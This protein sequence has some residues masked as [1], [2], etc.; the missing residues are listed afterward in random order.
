MTS[1]YSDVEIPNPQA[2]E[3]PPEEGEQEV[4]PG[5]AQRIL[6]NQARTEARL[7]TLQRIVG[8]AQ[9][10]GEDVSPAVLKQVERLAKDAEE[11]R[12]ERQIERL[13]LTE[14]QAAAF[15][16]EA[17]KEESKPEAKPELTEAILE[18]R[19]DDVFNN[20]LLPAFEQYV[21]AQGY[22]LTPA[23]HNEL[24]ERWKVVEIGFDPDTGQLDNA[25]IKAFMQR[26]FRDIDTTIEKSQGAKPPARTA[27]DA[28]GPKG[29][30]GGAAPAGL[31][32][33]EEAEKLAAK[34][35]LSPEI[36]EKLLIRG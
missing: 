1:T 2:G 30:P 10:R 27:G 24:Y 6:D 11:G 34:G 25:D 35:K 31:P 26:G 4:V 29:R 17:I 23:N 16:K 22:Q 20:L 33:W 5:Y 19:T 36:M 32:S 15:R 14:E 9:R 3:A 21:E 13:G 18:A 7:N 8:T 28:L 12:V